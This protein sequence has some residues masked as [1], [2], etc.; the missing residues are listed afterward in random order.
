MYIIVFLLCCVIGGLCYYIHQQNKKII[1]I[2]K[3]I[4]DILF[5]HNDFYIQKYKEGNLSILESDICKLVNKIY[6]QNRL[7]ENEKLILKEYLEDISHQ[8][9]TPLTSLNLIHERLQKAEGHEKRQLL[10]EEKKLLDKIEW[11]VMSLL[12]MAQLDAQTVTF[13]QESIKQKDFVLQLLNPFEIQIDMKDIQLQINIQESEIFKC[14]ILWTLEALSN[15]LKNCIEHVEQNGII[16]IE[17]NQNPLYNEIIIQ[18]NGC[19]I[20][21]EDL[22]HLFERFYKGKNAKQDS[23]GIGLALS[24]M[25]IEKQNGTIQVENTYPGTKFT[26]HLY[27][28]NV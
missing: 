1:S 15:I 28:E 18:D 11:L 26:I 5:Q 27:K 17:M 6:E 2:S 16:H 13:H 3:Q 7:L 20:D 23:V 4:N 24:S 12:K 14:D 9:K 25:I 22:I 21:Q 10:K 19:G 8:M